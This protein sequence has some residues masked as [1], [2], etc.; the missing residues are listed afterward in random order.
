MKK[1]LLL[2][3]ITFG[4]L[5]AAR[6]TV[7][8][9]DA[10]R[11][12][13]SGNG[14]SW[15]QAKRDVQAAINLAAT[16]GDEVRIKAGTYL[17]TMDLNGNAS[18]P[19]RDRAFY[20]KSADIKLYGGYSASDTLAVRNPVLNTTIL[21]G[22]FD[23]TPR[24]AFHILFTIKRTT[25]C[26]IDGFSF[27]WGRAD[28][29]G[30][31]TVTSDAVT[32]N[33][34]SGGGIY[35]LGSSPTISNCIFS[36][37]TAR[38]FGGGMY[39][40]NNGSRRSAPVII[41]CTFTSNRSGIH[42][43][44]MFNN[45]SD[46]VV[47]GSTFSFNKNSTAGGGVGAGIY[48]SNSSLNVTNTVF[49]H[50]IADAGSCL[51]N[52]A[53][54]VSVSGCTFSNDSAVVGG[55]IQSSGSTLTVTNSTFLNNKA[56]NI[57]GSIE[58]DFSSAVINN[59]TFTNCT[60]R[61]GGAVFANSY[62][63]ITLNNC[64]FTGNQ[65]DRGGAVV[66]YYN[67]NVIANNCT[68]NNNS[69]ND[70]GALASLGRGT[71]TGCAFNSNAAANNGGGTYNTGDEDGY[72][73]MVNCTFNTNTAI[74]D[75]GG[76]Y[77]TTNNTM[78]SYT[79]PA[80]TG[81]TFSNNSAVR[82]GGL[83]CNNSN[84]PY[85]MSS[86]QLK[87]NTADTGGGMF[88]IGRGSY[89]KAC[90][91]RNNT[92]TLA[93][94]LYDASFDASVS[95]SAFYGNTATGN[96]GGL[97][98]ASLNRAVSSCLFADN[99]AGGTG[100]GVYNDATIPGYI[101]NENNHLFTNCTFFRNKA[102]GSGS[103]GGGFYSSGV[104]DGNITNSILYRNT[105]PANPGD[106]NRE[107]IYAQPGNNLSAS[108]NVVGDYN[109]GAAN[110]YTNG[111][112]IVTTYP[113]FADTTRIAGIDS[114]L[115]TADDGLRIGCSSPAK[116]AGDPIATTPATDILNNT[117]AGIPDLGA[118]EAT[119][120]TTA[121]NTI[122]MNYTTVSLTQTA[123]ILRYTDCT[124]ELLKID[125]TSPRTLSGSVVVKTYIEG[126]TMFFGSSN[127]YVGR[128]YDIT[129]AVNATTATAIVT[130]YFTQAEFDDYN[131]NVSGL[132]FLPSGP[133]D[134]SGINNVRI[135]QHHG[136]STTGLPGTY[137]GPGSTLINP[138]AVTWNNAAGRWE[139]TFPV[140]GFSGF[141][142]HTGGGIPL[143]VTLL[144]FT[145][146]KL[147]EHVNE[148]SWQTVTETAGSYFTLE[149]SNNGTEFTPIG[150]AIAGKGNNASYTFYDEAPP[151]SAT[152]YRLR[153]ES[154]DG[155]ERYSRMVKLIN[156]VSANAVILFPNPAS[157]SVQIQ[158]SAPP[159]GDW[160]IMVV[161]SVGSIVYQQKFDRAEQTPL[162]RLGDVTAGIYM[163]R[164][165]CNGA[166][167]NTRLVMIR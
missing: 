120:G 63:T 83:Y 9:V 8:Y 157:G 36:N 51:Y 34:N 19:F 17:P 116:D 130:L 87:N 162:L 152:Y 138:T 132:P 142:L 102:T 84:V 165:H 45:N 23:N 99:T 6:A 57:G 72:L 27:Q 141:F 155:G 147:K 113:Q 118:Y 158:W 35:N 78:R 77:I 145:G 49:D 76:I 166:V 140:T 117:R 10:A 146:R 47:S 134:V 32:V 52:T 3:L 66:G 98:A 112:N 53:A 12:D 37:D 62:M 93:G 85:S 7:Y 44:G 101:L 154:G 54:N 43:A 114:L 92:A 28:S 164:A 80:I 149:R 135:S 1:L 108:Y 67:S 59:S 144:S 123:A 46:P 58:C 31:F 107:D 70:G 16:N 148:L 30:S 41:N 159:A 105:T 22:D 103:V 111:G 86:C 55:A 106:A 26:V 15:A 104:S 119:G 21:S 2:F 133:G 163:V 29:L 161:N 125:A 68:F 81:C 153:I 25:A 20:I 94:G 110:N 38:N 156:E 150:N 95:N 79:P 13:N 143:P 127:A 137:S 71:L 65:A 75:G 131:D 74:K 39:N 91:F 126:S 50:N 42:G 48:N 18:G 56:P 69:A 14:L 40:N 4:C 109:N 100:G 167:Y 61:D 60:S 90:I 89:I 129:P 151:A 24:D 121:S 73:S 115:I 139:I 122:P 124:N 33:R 82:G 128:H 136:T 11:A 88:I 96:A 97:Y 5:P 64:T 160:D